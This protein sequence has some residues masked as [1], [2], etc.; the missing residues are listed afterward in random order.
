MDQ[1]TI[2]CCMCKENTTDYIKILNGYICE[3]CERQIS[4][5]DIDD[6]AYEYYNMVLKKIWHN[7]LISYP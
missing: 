2:T 5:L 3:E 4:T 1:G 6:V 7:F